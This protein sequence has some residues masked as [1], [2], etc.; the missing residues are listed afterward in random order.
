MATG[1][2]TSQVFEIPTL[3]RAQ[4]T[5]LHCTAYSKGLARVERFMDDARQQSAESRRSSC[6]E[7]HKRDRGGAEQVRVDLIKIAVV[8]LED[9]G[10]RLTM[11]R[12]A[13]AR[14][15]GTDRLQAF[16]VAANPERH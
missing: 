12:R 16:V 8:A 11:I 9:G 15:L 14:H 1:G 13:A 10:K 6:V 5:D 2:G 4:N 3:Q 7:V